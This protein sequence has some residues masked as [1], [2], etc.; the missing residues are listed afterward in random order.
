MAYAGLGQAHLLGFEQGNPGNQWVTNAAAECQRSLAISPET[1]EEHICLGEVA[2]VTG[3]YGRAIEQLQHALALDPNNERAL[4]DLASSYEKQGNNAAAE[5]TYQKAITVRPQYWAGYNSL[6]AFYFRHAKYAEA[7][8]MFH[9]VVEL[10]PENFRGYSNLG[11]VYVTQGHYSE[12]ID[13]LKHSVE[14]RPNFE[15]LSNLGT[16]YF[17]LRR[18]DQ[19]S[20]SYEQALKLDDS[21]WLLWGNLGDALYWTNRRRNEAA[22]AYRKA[23][24]LCQLKLQVNPEDATVRAFLA[25]YQGMIGEKDKAIQDIQRALAV[26]PADPEVRF[27]A[28]LVYNQLGETDLCLGSLGKALQAG[29]PASALRDTPDFDLL[30]K[31]A[32]FQSLL[33][34][35]SADPN[36]R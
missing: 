1:A 34:N 27:R 35:N 28:A 33:G 22:P 30:R 23:V 11:G 7:A 32:R 9:R 26:A 20:E 29:Y 36:E 3:Q 25:T 21:N 15:V 6:G 10:T 31:N 2:R 4:S 17:A 13:A 14:I 16:A 12:A 18:F 8:E 5:A 19:A 24:S